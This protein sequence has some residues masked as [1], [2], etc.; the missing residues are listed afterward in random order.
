METWRP[1]WSTLTAVV[2][3]AWIA[4]VSSCATRPDRGPWWLYQMNDPDYVTMF[5]WKPAGQNWHFALVRGDK[6]FIHYTVEEI[7]DDLR[8]SPGSANG[9]SALEQQLL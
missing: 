9:I 8:R 4:L 1:H 2:A 5:S 7:A 3:L 6:R